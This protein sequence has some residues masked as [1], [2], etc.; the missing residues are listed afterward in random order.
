LLTAEVAWAASD[1]KG[2]STLRNLGDVTSRGDDTPLLLLATLALLL[3]LVSR[4]DKDVRESVEDRVGIGEIFWCRRDETDDRGDGVLASCPGAG[5]PVA[6]TGEERSISPSF[7]SRPSPMGPIPP[8]AAP[9]S[10]PVSSSSNPLSTWWWW[11]LLLSLLCP[12]GSLSS[13]ETDVI[14]PSSSSV[15][16]AVRVGDSG[17]VC[18]DPDDR[19]EAGVVAGSRCRVSF[20]PNCAVLDVL[21]VATRFHAPLTLPNRSSCVC[22]Y[23]HESG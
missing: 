9:M 11:L 20:C 13:R 12:R 19:E 17:N 2:T 3:L 18:V 21:I 6:V 22:C 8:P 14:S 5:V 23:K 4:R 16:K 1:A 7:S 15:G 10:P